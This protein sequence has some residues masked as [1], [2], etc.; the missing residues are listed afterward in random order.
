M[1]AT[2]AALTFAAGL[3]HLVETPSLYGWSWDVYISDDEGEPTED[4]W[5]LS[6]PRW[7]AT[8]R[9]LRL[10]AATTAG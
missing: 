10:A 9:S 7:R 6:A 2:T 3:D 5:T 8:M 4:D 1:A